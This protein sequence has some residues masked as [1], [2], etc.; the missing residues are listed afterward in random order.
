MVAFQRKP[1]S[2]ARHATDAQ[3]GG[4]LMLKVNGTPPMPGVRLLLRGNDEK[5]SS[6]YPGIPSVA[7]GWAHPHA[8]VAVLA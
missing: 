5:G 2:N 6:F 4:F 7:G 1:Q 8:A 3:H